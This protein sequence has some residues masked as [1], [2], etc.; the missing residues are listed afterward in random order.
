[1]TMTY[2]KLASKNMGALKTM[3]ELIDHCFALG[4]FT[5]PCLVAEWYS[6]CSD[7]VCTVGHLNVAGILQST[8][9][10]QLSLLKL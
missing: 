2:V 1:M 4:T 9:S 10:F 5:H 6:Y 7:V 8:F 3:I